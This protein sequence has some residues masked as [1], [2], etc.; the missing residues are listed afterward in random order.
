MIIFLKLTRLSNWHRKTRSFMGGIGVIL[1]IEAYR[2]QFIIE[3]VF[4]EMKD[5]STGNL[6]SL[7]YWT[8]ANIQVHG[9]YCTIAVLLRSLM[10]R[11][12]QQAGINLSMKRLFFLLNNIRE[13]V[14][15][16]PRKGCRKVE[17]SQT[18]LTKR[19]VLQNRL[20][21]ILGLEEG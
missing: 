1:I 13:V 10:L 6:W 20:M 16:Y 7:Y 8:D 3:D 21:A 9:L 17:P 2:S 11:R 15:I 4:K 12:I 5:R 19:S 18:V 14:N